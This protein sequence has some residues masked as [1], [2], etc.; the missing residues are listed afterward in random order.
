[1][2]RGLDGGGAAWIDLQTDVV[3]RCWPRMM[4][5]RIPSRCLNTDPLVH[6]GNLAKRFVD[7]GIPQNIVNSLARV[8]NRTY[9]P[10]VWW[11]RCVWMPLPYHPMWHRALSKALRALS[12]EPDM[13]LL[14]VLSFKKWAAIKVR[15][16][17]S[18]MLPPLAA[19][20]KTAGR[21]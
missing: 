9:R 15:P 17:W 3:G 13:R 16:A 8:N 12:V 19:R 10:R 2:I 1:M 21:R 7:A 4:M 18:N 14:L 6:I 11:R 20:I 5:N